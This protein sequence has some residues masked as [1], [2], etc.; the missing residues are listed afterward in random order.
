MFVVRFVAGAAGVVGVFATGEGGRYGDY[1][2]RW[3]ARVGDGS[4]V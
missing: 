3:F 4:G 1:R 2:N